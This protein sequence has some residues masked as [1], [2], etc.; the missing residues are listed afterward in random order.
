M[1]NLYPRLATGGALAV[2][3]DE[4]HICYAIM[5]ALVSL[6]LFCVLLAV[7]SPAKACVITSLIV[8]LFGLVAWLAPAR[9]AVPAHRNGAG[10]GGRQPAPTVRLVRR[11]TCGL[12]D[13]A[14]GAL[15]TFAYD[16]KG[17]DEPRAS[18]QLLCAVCLEDVHG[19]EMVR[20]LP[21]CR[22]LFHVDC[23]DMWL[24]THRT[25]PLCRCELS[26]RKAAAKAAAAAV[27]G[28]SAHPLPP[29]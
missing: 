23:I 11:C 26:P 2:D 28:S 24:H 13:A 14:I 12:T 16:S 6:L 1:L 9:G 20:Q 29:V 22:H 5:V 15:P 17:G 8:L 10:L 7:V 27:T 21:P 19:G 25:C 3:D 4:P 18:C